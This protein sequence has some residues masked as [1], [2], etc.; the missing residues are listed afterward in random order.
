MKSPRFVFY[1]AQVHAA[2]ARLRNKGLMFPY[3]PDVIEEYTGQ[4][5]DLD[6]GTP[7]A[8]SWNAAFG[9]FMKQHRARL[10]IAHVRAKRSYLTTQ[11]K[12]TTCSLW[13][14]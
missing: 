7:A 3:T 6:H 8:R 10:R 14:I 2:L 4:P 12:R 1:P 13:S 9:R 11:G 5:Y